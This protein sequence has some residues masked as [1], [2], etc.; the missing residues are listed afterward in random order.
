MR[1]IRSRIGAGYPLHAEPNPT[2]TSPV[3]ASITD[4]G[5]TPRATPTTAAV[6]VTSG[7]GTIASHDASNLA[8]DQGSQGRFS[9]VRAH[10]EEDVS[11]DATKG[12]GC[13]LVSALGH[14]TPDTSPKIAKRMRV[15]GW[16]GALGWK[17]T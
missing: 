12:G 14:E 16:G 4:P 6:A 11:G 7:V 15:R 17:W 5:E 9:L 13:D 3:P 8:T 10:L 2:R 1:Q